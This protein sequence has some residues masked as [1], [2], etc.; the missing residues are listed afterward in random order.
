MVMERLPPG[1]RQADRVSERS[2]TIT[3]RNG[4]PFPSQVGGCYLTDRGGERMDSLRTGQGIFP[5]PS[6]YPTPDAPDWAYTLN[7]NHLSD[8]PS[9]AQQPYK[10]RQ[11]PVVRPVRV[12]GIER[13][14]APSAGTGGWNEP[15]P[16]GELFPPPSA[17]APANPPI[18][19]TQGTPLQ[20]GPPMPIASTLMTA[21]SSCGHTATRAWAYLMLSKFP[22]WGS[23]RT[24]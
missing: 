24:R 8:P 21:A 9:F 10:G 22:S 12:S 4:A 2:L 17:S 3:P 19:T 16:E 18:G 13:E 15:S 23:K 6:P 14:W 7:P 5:L 1:S 20:A 11:P